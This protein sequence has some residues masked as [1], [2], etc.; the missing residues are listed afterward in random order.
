MTLKQENS[1]FKSLIF[2]ASDVP[3][4]NKI[5]L[6]VEFGW[7]VFQFFQFGKEYQVPLFT[8]QDRHTSSYPGKFNSK[9]IEIFHKGKL[10]NDF[11]THFKKTKNS[12]FPFSINS[13]SVDRKRKLNSIKLLHKHP[14][15]KKHIFAKENQKNVY[16]NKF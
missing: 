15:E 7:R 9:N 8:I 2:I 14:T 10:K 16:I 1:F 6:M 12:K 4:W 5:L 13:V 3:N 11:K